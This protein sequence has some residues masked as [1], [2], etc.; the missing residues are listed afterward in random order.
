MFGKPCFKV[1]NKAFV[2]FFD[3]QM[4]F[5]LAGENLT[6]ALM[7]VG[8]QLFDPSRKNRPMKQWVQLSFDVKVR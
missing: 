7:V 1:N 4:V 2:C 3:N 5:K 6:D 8:S